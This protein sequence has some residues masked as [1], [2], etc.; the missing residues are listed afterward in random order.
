MQ[1]KQGVLLFLWFFCNLVEID[2]NTKDPFAQVKTVVSD[3]VSAYF[4]LQ[5]SLQAKPTDTSS[6]LQGINW[7]K[8][9]PRYR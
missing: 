8:E 1:Y 6:S 4:S 3:A 7:T 5:A 2:K 9:K